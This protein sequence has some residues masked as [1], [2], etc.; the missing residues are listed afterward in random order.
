MTSSRI[1]VRISALVAVALV[2]AVVPAVEAAGPFSYYALTPCRVADTRGNGFTGSYGP[3]SLVAFAD[4]S[5]T[6]GGQ[7]G[8]P[9]D[10]AAVTF[11]FTIVNTTSNGDLRVFPA[12]VPLPVVSTLN[13][14]PA[15]TVIANGALVPLGTGGAITVHNDGSTSVNLVIDVTGYFK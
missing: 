7:C 6:I 2:F 3:P 14:I 10:A 9:V 1:S 4:R 15:T 8:I 5:F 12:G 11:N 13:W